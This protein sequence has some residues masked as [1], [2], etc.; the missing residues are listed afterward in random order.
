MKSGTSSPITER[1]GERE[2]V[3]PVRTG[4]S[5]TI[6]RGVGFQ[7]RATGD[8]PLCLLIATLPRW[9]G[10]EAAVDV[11]GPWGGEAPLHDPT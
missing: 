5:L 3:E 9:P 11:T 6:P 2:A 10:P 8:D 1:S 4:T 7:F